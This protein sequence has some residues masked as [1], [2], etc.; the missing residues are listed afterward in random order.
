[1]KTDIKTILDLAGKIIEVA[2]VV[3]E[4]KKKSKPKKEKSK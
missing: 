4:P 1:M 2:K 3:L